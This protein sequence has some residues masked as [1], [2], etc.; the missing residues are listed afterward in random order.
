MR[1]D[2]HPQ[3]FWRA[4]RECF[5]V[6]LGGKQLRLDPDRD[7][8]FNMY[9][10]LMSRGSKAS[11][12]ARLKPVR[13]DLVVTLLDAFLEWVKANNAARTYVW[14]ADY[15]QAFVDMIPATLKVADLKP[16]HLSRVMD[17]KPT[18]SPSTKNGFARSIQRAMNW[19][20]KQELTDRNPV[21][22]VE[23]PA[24]EAREVPLTPAEFARLMKLAKDEPIR[25]VMIAAWDSGARPNEL[26]HVEAR[27]CEF[28]NGRWVFN[29]KESIGKKKPRV[30]YVSD[31]VLDICRRRA[32]EHP[33][34]L[35]FRGVAGNSTDRRQEVPGTNRPSRRCRRHGPASPRQRA[36]GL[37][38]RERGI[39]KRRPQLELMPSAGEV[40]HGAGDLGR[41]ITKLQLVSNR[42]GRSVIKPDILRRR[43]YP[44]ERLL[45]RRGRGLGFAASGRAIRGSRVGKPLE[46]LGHDERGILLIGDHVT[47][48]EEIVNPPFRIFAVRGGDRLF[49]AA[50]DDL[51]QLTPVPKPPAIATSAGVTSSQGQC[52]RRKPGPRLPSN[53][54]R[55]ERPTGRLIAFQ[56]R[57]A[58]L[59]GLAFRSDASM[60]PRTAP[61]MAPQRENT[62]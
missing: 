36:G 45:H 61:R 13:T 18:W 7:T 39:V 10:E 37:G 59:T 33:H 48:G 21:R 20:V 17:A 12:Q 16:S 41:S 11:P 14:Y 52:R 47:I 8:A 22:Y 26:M 1:R 42:P 62:R 35:I 54:L 15:I 58:S 23:K 40:G 29:R 19:A 25:E 38:L 27:H 31:H 30:V 55:R 2:Q 9:H 4:A 53:R 51:S 5:F 3:P 50:V 56:N 43:D 44:I 60:N 32:A 49:G 28:P 34:G 24:L 57:A 6:Q 46:R